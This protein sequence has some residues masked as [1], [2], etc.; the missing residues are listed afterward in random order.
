MVTVSKVYLCEPHQHANEMTGTASQGKPSEYIVLV[1]LLQGVSNAA[2]MP[3]I[4]LASHNFFLFIFNI[5]IES[6]FLFYQ[7]TVR[8]W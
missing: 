8:H 5:F 7:N 3:A 6:S 4:L 1:F 2:K